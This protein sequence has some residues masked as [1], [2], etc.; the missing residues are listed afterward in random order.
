MGAF[1]NLEVLD[2]GNNG[3]GGTVPRLDS[4]FSLVVFRVAG[5][6]LFGMMP[7]ALLQN[8][9]RLVEIDLSRNGFSGTFLFL[10]NGCILSNCHDLPVGIPT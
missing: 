6:G 3:I 4:W 1:K 10:V 2:L 9:M 7:E 5:N 8:S